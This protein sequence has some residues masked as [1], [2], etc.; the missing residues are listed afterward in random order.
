MYYWSSSNMDVLS[1]LTLDGSSCVDYFIA[2]V[3]YFKVYFILFLKI[4]ILFIILYIIE[5]ILI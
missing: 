2:L 3:M 1:M 5:N 4:I